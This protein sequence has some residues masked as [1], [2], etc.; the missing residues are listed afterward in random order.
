[1]AIGGVVALESH[2]VPEQT[3]QNL[4]SRLLPFR[5]GACLR[6]QHS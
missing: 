2:L 4:R 3:L 1:M 5:C 6:Q